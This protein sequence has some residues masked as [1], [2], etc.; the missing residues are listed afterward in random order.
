MPSNDHGII[1]ERSAAM[2]ARFV[3]NDRESLDGFDASRSYQMVPLY[4]GRIMTAVTENTACLAR[5]NDSQIAG[6][7]DPD[8]PWKLIKEISIPP[9]SRKSFVIWGN[10]VGLD[11]VQL[12]DNLGMPISTITVSVK[13]PVPHSYALL[14]LADTAPSK[15]PTTRN[16]AQAAELMKLVEKTYLKQ[17]NVQLTQLG[18]ATDVTI[19]G[20]LGFPLNVDLVWGRIEKATPDG[21]K[22]SGV[23]RMYSCWDVAD[24]KTGDTPV[25]D[26]RNKNCFIE[27]DTDSRELFFAHELGHALGL[28]HNP[29]AKAAAPLL[30][31]DDL[32][33]GGTFKLEQHEID[34]INPSGGL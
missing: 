23:I 25:G 34:K 7:L 8:A 28:D 13:S 1:R 31:G 4:G 12:I 29:A 24:D 20:N 14:F 22:A 9:H 21:F 2:V 30:M 10:G 26:T 33:K 18:S 17:A 16:K 5:P 27:D 19:P 15:H 11:S 3:K 6:L 32:T